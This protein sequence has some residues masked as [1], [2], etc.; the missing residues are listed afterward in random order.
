MPR[1]HPVLLLARHLDL[2]G[3]ERQLAEMARQLDRAY[4]EPHVACFSSGG[5]R[6]AE[7]AQA[8][9][10]VLSLEMRSF[11]PPASLHSARR[12]VDYVRRQRIEL[13]H[14]FDVPACLFA[15]PLLKTFS[16]AVV[17]SSQRAHRELVAGWRRHLLRII[18]RLADGV[19]VNC[20]F[21]QQHLTQEERIPASRIHL[22]YNGIDTNVFRPPACSA[23][24]MSWGQDLHVGVVCALRPEKDLATLLDAFA[25]V[26]HSR[27]GLKLL[28]VGG[29]P[30]LPALQRRV[31]DL[32]IV[33]DCIFQPAT[34]DVTPWLHRIDIFVL[35][36]RSE[37]LSNSLMEAM[38]SGCCAIASRVGGNPELVCHGKT[39]LLFEP[40][41]AE[42]LAAALE[43]LISREPFRRELASAGQCLIQENFSLPAAAR[44][45]SE[46]YSNLLAPCRGAPPL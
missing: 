16:S 9:I 10:P 37:A 35:P 4:F 11:K 45:M 20:R 14:A 12:L 38:A 5:R 31:R 32:Q 30:C 18:D 22:C 29:G 46:I 42:D 33:S 39:G 15:V 26:R 25:M 19:V 3:T 28:I 44:R 21:L 23:S 7:L 36:S 2:G 17:L 6:A 24:S 8:G 34:A 41:S 40:G 43:L 13:L 27:P 1:P